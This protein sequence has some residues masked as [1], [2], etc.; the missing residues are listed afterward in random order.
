M[1]IP[2]FLLWGKRKKI[3]SFSQRGIA[4]AGTAS[5]RG[6]LSVSSGTVKP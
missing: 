2:N 3:S 6:L 4:I 1:F 5:S